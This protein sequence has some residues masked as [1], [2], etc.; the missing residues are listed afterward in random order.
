M[1]RTKTNK[2]LSMVVVQ[3][4]IPIT[5][6]SKQDSSFSPSCAVRIVCLLNFNCDRDVQ[7]SLWCYFIHPWW[8]MK[9]IFSCVYRPLE[10]L[11]RE[12]SVEIFVYC[13][14]SCCLSLLEPLRLF[15]YSVHK[16]FED[17][18]QSMFHF[19]LFFL[20]LIASFDKPKFFHFNAFQMYWLLWLPLL[21]YYL[22]NF[23]QRDCSSWKI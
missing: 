14:K 6:V 21:A 11:F 7:T 16:S 17:S 2:K 22:K 15:L 10:I 9:Q 1:S 8:L 23:W 13:K 12:V 5:A 3:F 20:L 4:Y 18:D 19:V